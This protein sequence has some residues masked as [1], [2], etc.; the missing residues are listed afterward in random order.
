MKNAPAWDIMPCGFCKNRRFGGMTLRRLLVTANVVRS[1]PIPVTLM[2]EALRSSEMS[3]IS[4]ATRRNVP[5]VRIV[6]PTISLLQFSQHTETVSL[7]SVI[8]LTL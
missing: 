5:E 7:N 2:M 3:V 4:R 1:S 6:H 8:G